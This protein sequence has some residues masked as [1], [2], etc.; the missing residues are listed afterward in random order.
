MPFIHSLILPRS[1]DQ[2][3]FFKFRFRWTNRN[4]EIVKISTTDEFNA[5]LLLRYKAAES[6][7]EVIT[8]QMIGA[9]LN[10]NNYA[11]KMHSLL[12]LEEMMQTAIVSQ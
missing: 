1:A 8:Q 7:N 10:C 4:R 12:K 5:K 2:N 11:H 3:N 9:E 6:A